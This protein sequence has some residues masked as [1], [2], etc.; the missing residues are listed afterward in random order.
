MN[1]DVAAFINNFLS[2]DKEKNLILRA[3]WNNDSRFKEG[4]S[5]LFNFEDYPNDLCFFNYFTKDDNLKYAVIAAELPLGLKPKNSSLPENWEMISKLLSKL[6]EDGKLIVITE[7][8]FGH[9]EQSRRFIEECSRKGAPLGALIETP[10]D[11]LA[12]ITKL[13]PNLAIFFKQTPPKNII[14]GS[15][16]GNDNT[17]KLIK[18]IKNNTP[19]NNLN[20]GTTINDFKGFQNYRVGQSIKA[21]Q[22]QYKEF[23]RVSLR[24]ITLNIS[25]TKNNFQEIEESKYLYITCTGP[26]TVHSDINN[27]KKK[28]QNYYQLELNY[29]LVDPV[30]L[31]EFMGTDLGQLTLQS[32]LS[33]TFS[34]RINKESLGDISIPLPELTTQKEIVKS[35]NLLRHMKQVL[36]K[37]ERDLSLNP[38][39]A[40]SIT[41]KLTSPLQSLNE[42]SKEDK[43]FHYIRQGEGLKVEFKETFSIDTKKGSQEKY[44]E[45]SSLKNIVGFL[46]KLGGTLLIGVTDNGIISGIEKD[47]F[48]S[49]DKYL[50]H[51]KNKI[52]SSIGEEYFS[53]I[54]YEIC[55]ISNKKVLIV[56]CSP[57]TKPVYL[58]QKDFYVRT[59][60]ATDKLEGP[61]LVEYINN[62]FRPN[63]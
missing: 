1:N 5:S 45:E 35:Y 29:D 50:L 30:Y 43:I 63:V 28:H 39:A 38:K 20:E 58:N 26:L 3:A 47:N 31:E 33:G 52:K 21:L 48:K 32:A 9:T 53:L 40:I 55:K 44:I 18:N 17:E 15:I 14:F 7:P 8:S 4:L 25:V 41:E 24:D 61:K 46:N 13:R 19:S 2:K 54:T 49:D 12:P 22:T 6:Q 37:L 62:H 16:S 27:L 57:S 51:F 10:K 60:P 42:L 59:N 11:I 36:S 23:R 56:E 34:P